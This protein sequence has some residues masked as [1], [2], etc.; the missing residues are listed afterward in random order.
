MDKIAVFNHY[1]NKLDKM[2]EDSWCFRSFLSNPFMCIER[3][4]DFDSDGYILL[5]ATRCCIIDDDYDYVVKFDYNSDETGEL[6]SAREVDLYEC[7]KKHNLEKFFTEACF[8]GTYER[9]LEWYAPEIVGDMTDNSEEDFRNFIS[10]LSDSD[11]SM[12]TISIPLYGYKKANNYEWLYR[13]VTRAEQQLVR[14]Y[15][16]SP[17]I[18]R[19]IN[20]GA[21]FLR[22]Y[23]VEDFLRLSK[24]CAKNNIND[25][26]CSNVGLI[27]EKIVII[28]YAGYVY[29]NSNNE[30]E[31]EDEEE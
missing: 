22:D 1:C 8:L 6:G 13:D 20:V 18:E 19:N 3:D 4:Y 25:I 28:D 30:D 26:H 9:T 15:R 10:T 27:D 29:D 16:P 12:I 11:K 23:G 21:A 31:Y 14:K 7:A 5:G 17:L 24:F 2:I